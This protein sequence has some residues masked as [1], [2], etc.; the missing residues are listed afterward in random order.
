MSSIGPQARLRPRIIR[1]L[2]NTV[3][4]AALFTGF[5]SIVAAIDGHFE[6]ASAAIFVAMVLDGI[7]GRIAR[8]TN[9]Q[10]DFG[11]QYDALSDLVCFGIAP[12]LLA[13]QWSLSSAGKLGWI[14]AFLFL[15]VG[16][17]RIARF[18]IQPET[19]TYRHLHGLPLP[20]AAAA[21]VALLWLAEDYGVSGDQVVLI[22]SSIMIVATGLMICN[23]RYRSFKDFSPTGG[24]PVIVVLGTVTLF[25]CVFIGLPF[26]LSLVS[27]IYVASGPA[28]ALWGTVK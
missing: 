13:F 14:P 12:S 10:S 6:A 8:A 20:P 4:T 11:T 5:Y 21:V 26:V 27:I 19:D 2:A 24:I 23:V 18:N 22:A 17:V 1:Q 3:T 25:M 16:V 15:V 9:S 28:L 7:D